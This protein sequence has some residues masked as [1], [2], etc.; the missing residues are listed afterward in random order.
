MTSNW[1]IN[2]CLN[3]EGLSVTVTTG[4][5]STAQSIPQSFQEL[6]YRREFTFWHAMICG[7]ARTAGYLGSGIVRLFLSL[8][9]QR[10]RERTRPRAGAP[11]RARPAGKHLG[12]IY[13]CTDFRF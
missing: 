12:S 8:K 2:A 5:G 6:E 10:K 3:P 9:G 7:S 13:E 11:L 4:P 1:L